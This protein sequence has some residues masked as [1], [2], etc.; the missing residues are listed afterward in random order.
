MRIQT[1]VAPG[2]CVSFSFACDFLPM[3]FRFLSLLTGALLLLLPLPID[4]VQAQDWRQE[5]QLATP[6]EYD[7]PLQ[8]LTDSL[9]ALFSR[10]PEVLV[11]R[12]AQDSTLIPA[13]QLREQLYEDGVGISSATHA[14]IRYRFEL[15]RSSEVVETITDIYF[16]YRGSDSQMD[17]PVL[18]VDTRE[19]AMNALLRARGIPSLMNMEAVT[20]FRDLLSFP[21]LKNHQETAVVEFAGR[22]LRG[23]TTTPEHLVFEEFLRERIGRGGGSYVLALPEPVATNIPAVDTPVC[24]GS[25]GGIE[26]P[27]GV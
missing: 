9:S 22:S 3:T 7:E 24:D 12:E 2:L 20:T 18:Y 15:G 1:Q 11:R 16:I 21:N 10:H 14:F 27:R 8:A 17:I 6:V 5:V 26:D 23:Y 4:T 13:S 25:F 19:S